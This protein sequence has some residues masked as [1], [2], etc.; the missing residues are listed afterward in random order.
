MTDL[1]RAPAALQPFGES[2]LATRTRALDW[3]ATPL[4]PID[5]WPQSLRTIVDMLLT[6]RF[7]MWMGWG[8]ALTFFYNDAYQRDTLGVKHPW[9]LGRPF[10]EVWAEISARPRAAHPQRAGDGAGDVG[11][12]AAPV[13][14]AERLRG[15]DVPHVLVQPAPGR[16]GPDRRAAERRRRG[17]RTGD[18]RAAAHGVARSRGEARASAP[19]ARRWSRRWLDRIAARVELA[20]EQ[21]FPTDELLDHVPLLVDGIA[22]Y[23]ERPDRGARRRRAG[24]RARR[25]SS[26]RCA[27]RRAST[28]TRSSRSTRSSA[29]I[30]F[31]FLASGRRVAAGVLAERD[32]WRAGTACRTPSRVIRQATTD[33]LPAAAGRAGERARGA[34]APL[35]PHGVARAEEPRRR[36]PRR[37]GAAAGAVAGGRASA[38]V[39]CA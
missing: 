3:S 31:A 34:A 23:L 21:V 36:D 18:R 12:G 15:G 4:G 1:E 30:L 22:D 9:A 29:A 32:R 8:P 25:W 10:R 2:E 11:R 19:Y 16:R 5:A 39:S 35:Q 6:S 28:R 7:S 27:T 14:S 26:A 17:D 20:P 33:A 37:G 24:D 13:P 38:S